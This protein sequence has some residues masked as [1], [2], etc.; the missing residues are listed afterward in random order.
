MGMKLGWRGIDLV[1][2]RLCYMREVVG[3][4]R[5]KLVFTRVWVV[6]SRRWGFIRGRIGVL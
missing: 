3:S 1:W 6:H 4:S 5:G 2:E